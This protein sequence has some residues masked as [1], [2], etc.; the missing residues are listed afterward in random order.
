MPV[1]GVCLFLAAL[2][3]LT[4]PAEESSSW[5]PAKG[6]LRTRW[7]ADVSPGKVHPEYPRPQL[8][9]PDWI[10]LNGLW[11]YAIR[12]REQERP[13]DFDG[14]ILV[15]FPV[16]SAL[17]GVMKPVKPGERLWYRRIAELPAVGKSLRWLLHFGA[18][19][20]DATVTVNGK[21]VG[22]HC[23]GF[24]PFTFDITD[25]IVPGKPQ[26]IVVA[27]WDPTDTESQPRGK[28]VLKPGGIMYTAVT[29]IWQTVWLE[30]VPQTRID[31]LRIVP[32]VDRGEVRVTAKLAGPGAVGRVAVTVLDG[33]K[34]IGTAEGPAGSPIV[35]KVPA[36]KLW[37]PD[38]PFLY[39]LKVRAADDEVASYF[40]MRKIALAKDGAGI[41]R[42]FLNGKPVFQLGPLDQ[43]WWPD[44][45]YTAPTD[46]AL[47]F[48]IEITKKLGFNMIRKH[49]KVEPERWY[50]WCDRLGILVWQ[51]MPSG[52]N[53][54]DASRKQFAAELARMIDARENHP[55][56]VM[57]VPFNE[58][59]GQH[60]TPRYVDW[61][62]QRDRTRLVNNA[63]GWI[64]TRTGD[65]SDMHNYPGPGMPPTEPN[66]AAV[67]GE[68]GG[69]GL[70][71]PGH[72]WEEKGNW[73][74]RT[75]RDQA[76]LQAG[77]LDVIGRLRGLAAMGLSAAV[78]TQT[79]DCEIE[80]NGLLTYDRAVVK[81]PTE[82]A[83]SAHEAIYGPLPS[84]KVVVGTAQ[85]GPQEWSYT[86]SKPGGEWTRPDFDD[87]AWMKGR[88]GFGTKGTP[89]AI[90]NTEWRTGEIWLRRSFDL[91]DVPIAA[92][93]LSIH[94]DE[95]AEVFVNGS[96][97]ARLQGYTTGY[98]VV[99]LDR[100]GASAFR[101]GRNVL[102]IHCRQTGGGQYIDAGILELI[103]RAPAAK[104]VQRNDP[105]GPFDVGVPPASLGLSP[106]YAKHVPV[107]GLPVVGSAK[108]S[109]FALKEAA[110]LVGK[111]LEHRPDVREA[112]VRNKVR[113]AIMAYSERTTDV[114]EHSDLTP[115]AYWDVRA[116]GLGAT[117]AR[118]AVSGAEENLL[119]YPGDPYSTENI[120]IHEFGHAMHEMGLA[121]ADPTFDRRLKQAFEAAGKGGLWKGTYA[122]TNPH[123]YW[124]EGVQSWFDTNRE[125]DSQHNQV[126]TREE[127]K[128]HDPALAALLKEVFGDTS[129]R[130]V[131]P[132]RRVDRAHLAGYDPS[133]A[134]R[135]AWEPELLEANRKL[136]GDRER[137]REKPRAG[138]AR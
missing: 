102:A 41:N 96:R 137:Q 52:D 17:S 115:K 108:V 8:V 7:A 2:L 67:L 99:P 68:F 112:M 78:Y 84:L 73:G 54:D 80:V 133:R 64:D 107:G 14:R 29:G 105:G 121:T 16:E 42:L 110:Y 24:D 11:D 66:R 60:E 106:F 40:G 94:H 85:N 74:Y 61:I 119:N 117:H 86:T 130:Y 98:G 21:E 49:V 55:S 125:N 57:W 127:L 37:S 136:R 26:E 122:A 91:G 65:V 9:R 46:E 28:Q 12:P 128:A 51:D 25:V 76:A 103:E 114:P 90:V 44:G 20:W 138:A 135:F 82:L 47:K 131:R 53:K 30:P 13:A 19:D 116:R 63:S 50:S 134:P 89:G 35:L 124:A 56:I 15:P 5:R 27:V 4:A 33:D 75:F 31:S 87:S 36:P 10:H 43:G 32:E 39:G 18:V 1:S 113:C 34:A 48:D 100:A 77:Y 129:W 101:P 118:P 111:M 38:T 123:E 120:L 70:P 23:G 62:R 79:T 6:P 72:L 92:P 83:A 93:Q 95:D 69:L 109:D 22:R 71:L 104:A 45:L 58:G 88:S 3:S 81:V 132:D 126:N 59:W 97:V